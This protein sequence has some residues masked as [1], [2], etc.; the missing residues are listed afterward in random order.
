MTPHLGYRPSLSNL[1]SV[2]SHSPFGSFVCFFYP[3]AMGMALSEQKGKVLP[4]FRQNDVV[5]VVCLCK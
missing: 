1:R 5:N 2:N 4:A 3:K